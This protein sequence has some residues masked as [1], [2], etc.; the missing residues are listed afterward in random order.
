MQSVERP[1][2]WR[3]SEGQSGAGLSRQAA[4]AEP[5][6]DGRC[7]SGF[8]VGA[9]GLIR[10]KREFVISRASRELQTSGRLVSAGKALHNPAQG[11]LVA[12]LGEQPVA[13][14]AN[15]LWQYLV[16]HRIFLPF[17]VTSSAFQPLVGCAAHA[18]QY[19]IIVAAVLAVDR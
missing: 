2:A 17:W 16:G 3:I 13:N 14:I 15:L 4:Y 18:G 19:N 10:L 8:S 1:A 5:G 12:Q 7:L 9:N 11:S 6:T